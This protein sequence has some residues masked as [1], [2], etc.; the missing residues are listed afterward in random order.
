MKKV[1][2][3]LIFIGALILGAFPAS[4]DVIKLKTVGNSGKSP[5]WQWAPYEKL[6]E[7][8]IVKEINFS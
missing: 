8:V 4:A 7:R 3:A 1:T 2:M 5:A 6:M